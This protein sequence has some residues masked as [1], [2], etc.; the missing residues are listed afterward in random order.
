M[1]Y[2][3]YRAIFEGLNAELWTRSSGR[4]LWMTQPAWPSTM[5]QIISNDYDTPAAFY[6]VK[7]AAEP[8]HIQM[9]QP[10]ERLQLVNNS[11][12]AIGNA[13][14]RARVFALDGRPLAERRFVMAVGADDVARGPSLHL[15]PLLAATGTIIVALEA[16]GP[17]GVVLSRNLYWLAR[18]ADASRALSRAPPQPI[19]LTAVSAPDGIDGD[20]HET[21]TVRNDGAAP[22]LNI[23][24]TLL[25]DR[26]E[27]ILPAYYSDNYLSLLPGESRTIDIAFPAAAAA[28]RAGGRHVAL[29]GWNALPIGGPPRPFGRDVKPPPS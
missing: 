22:A 20:A 6:A 9:S 24:L 3:T 13:R 11:L 8:V 23:K 18:D 14:V 29:R 4:M 16:D 27:R 15:A 5:W 2:E 21:A 12:V 7:S 1:N 19:A 17:K 25:D 26:G 10:D 28:A